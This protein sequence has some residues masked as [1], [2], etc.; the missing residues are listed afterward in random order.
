MLKAKQNYDTITLPSVIIIVI[1]KK[2]SYTPS[3]RYIA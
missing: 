1:I 2:E 3:V